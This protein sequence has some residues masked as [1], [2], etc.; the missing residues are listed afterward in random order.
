MCLD[1]AHL[2]ASGIDVTD[3]AAVEAMLDELDESIG[4]ERLK[5]LHIND[6]QTALG[7]NRDRHANVG[8]GMIG[9]GMAAFLGRPR[10]QD[11]PAVLETP[12]HDGKGADA[13]CLQQL[14]RL[15]RV[16]TG[17]LTMRVAV[18]DPQAFT[19]PYDDELCRAL[20]AAGAEV[21]LLTSRFTHGEAPPALGYARREL[22]GPPLAGL[23]ARR[24]SSRARIP[25]KAAGHARGPRAARPPRARTA[26]GHRALAVGTLACARPQGAARGA[27]RIRC[28]R[29]H[30][31]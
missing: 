25:L 23:I 29:L 16:G 14:E 3:V 22:F 6:S 26:A 30:C 20:A 1:S 10:L 12:G 27:A 28:D 15:W 9:E 11:L 4:L 13:R 7:S 24:P 8:E 17:E 5:A 31:A 21:E 2:Y 19:P 18:V